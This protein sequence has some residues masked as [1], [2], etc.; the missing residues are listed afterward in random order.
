MTLKLLE[1]LGKDEFNRVQYQLRLKLALSSRIARNG[2]Q[3]G[4]REL[5]IAFDK[6]QVA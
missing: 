1:I 3:T 6:E 5:Q 4:S 2:F